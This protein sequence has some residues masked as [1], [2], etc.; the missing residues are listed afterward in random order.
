VRRGLRLRALPKATA[1]S[2][3]LGLV[4]SENNQ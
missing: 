3:Y 2:A 4:P 1:L